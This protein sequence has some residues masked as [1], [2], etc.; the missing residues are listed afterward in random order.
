MPPQDPPSRA[1][2]SPRGR[3]EQLDQVKP[4][5]NSET[6]PMTRQDEMASPASSVGA[7]PLP[8]GGRVT[9]PIPSNCS[10]SRL[11]MN[12]SLCF[13]NLDYYMLYGEDVLY[14]EF[15]KAVVA[16]VASFA[17]DADRTRAQYSVR[18]ETPVSDNQDYVLGRIRIFDM[19]TATAARMISLR[20]ETPSQRLCD[21]L[22][23]RVCKVRDLGTC[24]F[25]GR[26]FQVTLPSDVH[27]PPPLP[28]P[29][30]SPRDGAPAP[31]PPPEK[32]S[33]E[34]SCGQQ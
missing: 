34:Q 20:L 28:P 23:K 30:G 18:L 6:R 15:Q 5:W 10:T 2:G 32:E 7:P 31:M 11:E 4:L 19:K 16:G 22:Q 21:S 12:F 14:E 8:M 29:S 9:S 13:A 1:L 26:E 3:R 27:D 25:A 33:T 17:G 24:I